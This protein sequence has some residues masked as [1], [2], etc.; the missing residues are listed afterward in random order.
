VT[1]HEQTQN[2]FYYYWASAA[3][4]DLAVDCEYSCQQLTSTTNAKFQS[5]FPVR[6]DKAVQANP[7]FAGCFAA[8]LIHVT[9]INFVS[10]SQVYILHA[11]QC[12]A[13]SQLVDVSER[14]METHFS[15][16]IYRNSKAVGPVVP[17]RSC[18]LSRKTT[19][20]NRGT[21]SIHFAVFL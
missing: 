16:G 11:V 15:M 1:P 9:R 7:D 4:H 10:A 2:T 17:K 20:V 14:C 13:I 6:L 8:M 5:N 12:I 3:N 19:T 21:W 18:L